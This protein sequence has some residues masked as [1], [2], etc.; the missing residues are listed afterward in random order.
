MAVYRPFYILIPAKFVVV[1]NRGAGCL[2][3]HD[4]AIQLGLLH[5][6]NTVNNVSPEIDSNNLRTKFPQV[7]DGVGKLKDYQQTI[8]VDP[9]IAP[10][11]QPPRRIPFHLQRQVATKL[12]ELQRLDIIETVNGP[13]PWVS[14]L[15]VVPKSNGEVRICVDMRQVNTTVIRQRYPIPTVETLHDLTGASVF[16][17][18]DLK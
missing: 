9:S 18:L 16:S 13:T 6:D 8:H 7:F 3:G 1:D 11:A 17:K 14:P 5:V 15:V 2:L 10:V 4:S 12:D